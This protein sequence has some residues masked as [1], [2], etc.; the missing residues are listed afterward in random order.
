MDDRVLLV[1]G[2]AD[3][4]FFVE[5]CK[6]LGLNTSVK[7]SPPKGLGGSQ[8]NK[9]GV[10]NFLPNMLKQM[11]DGRIKHLA[12]VVDADSE[13]HGGGYNRTV[14]KVTEIVK[15][16]GFTIKSG[17]HAGVIFKHDDELADFGLW[18]MPDNQ[19]KGML[20]DWIKECLSS[21]ENTLFEHAKTTVAALNNPKFKPIH[22][23]KAEI[24]TWLAWQKKPGHGLYIAIEDKL[25][26]TDSELYKSFCGWLNHIYPKT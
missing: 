6:N 18:V 23:S 21:D 26:D 5:I 15:E 1:E 8:N 2:E 24:A 19:N 12:I 9:E 13:E 11:P 25:L 20:E 10:F 17:S 4:S 22:N 7:V 16:Y 3:R 14:T